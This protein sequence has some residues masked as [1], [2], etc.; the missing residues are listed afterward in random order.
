VVITGDHGEAFGRH[1][2][3]WVHSR[4]SYQENFAVPLFIYQPKL[5]T[6]Q[7]IKKPS[8]HV[9][10]LPTLLSAMKVPYNE[11][12]IQ[13]ENILNKSW[14][15]KY[16]FFYGNEMQASSIQR[17]SNVKLQ[18]SLKTGRCRVLE[19]NRDPDEKSPISCAGHS[20][21][22]NALLAFVKYQNHILPAYN[23]SIKKG[24]NFFGQSH[25]GQQS[26]RL[27][28][29]RKIQHSGGI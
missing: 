26:S 25:P 4:D 22:K 2:N 8:L 15:R 19:L 27:A 17:T 28:V 23:D 7:K 20:V 9:D 24:Q 10:I 16:D 6:A 29:T 1:K 5:F 12:L 11:N 18:I 3:N 13:G 14:R 21:Q